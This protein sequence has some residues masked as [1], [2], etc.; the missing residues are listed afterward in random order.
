MD[1]NHLIVERRITQRVL[2]YW[3]SIRNGR[4][5]PEENDIDPDALDD[6]WLYCFLLQTRDIEHVEHF[7][8][9]YL[10][11]GIA[12]AYKTAQID[13]DNPFL[14]GPNAFYLEPHFIQVVKTKK[15]FIDE[16]DFIS[17]CGTRILYR[18]CLLPIGGK[19]GQVES[20]FGAMFFKT[21]THPP[22]SESCATSQY[23]SSA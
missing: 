4:A 1:D 14:I 21:D 17:N 13:P 12:R 5:M 6:D 3:E 20:I 23:S 2:N 19:N 22:P 8:F 18:Q 10:G 16:N 15:P 9:T 11:E 7:N